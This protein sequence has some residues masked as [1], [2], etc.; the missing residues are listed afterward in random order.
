MVIR[1]KDGL[2]K[3]ISLYKTTYFPKPYTH[4]KIK[5]NVELDLSNYAAKSN[6]QN[7]TGNHDTLKFARKAD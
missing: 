4:S 1:L 6:L 2:I 3:N 7:A 5:L